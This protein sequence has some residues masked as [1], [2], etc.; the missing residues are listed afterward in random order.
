MARRWLWLAS[1]TLL[2]AVL[3]GL[4]AA[5][6]VGAALVA[7]QHHPIGPAPPDLA[8]APV[9]IA[10]PDGPV[11]GWYITGRPEMASVLLLH[12]IR[13]D[14]RA[15]LGRARLLSRQGYAVL[16]IDLPAHGESGGERITLGWREAQGVVAARDWLRRQRPG[17]ALGV[18]G[19]SLGGA[20]VLLGPMPAGYDAV[21]LEA[22]YDDAG[23]ALRNRIAIR[24]GDTAARLLWP[25]LAVQAGPRMGVPLSQL[26]PVSRMDG[27]GAPVLVIAGGKDRHTT[28]AQSRSLF[29]HAR[30]P[31]S[32]WM[33]PAAAHQD[34]LRAD[35]AGY[36]RHVLDF[37]A[38][39]LPPASAAT[40]TASKG[41]SS[42]APL[43]A[44]R[45]TGTRLP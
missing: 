33:L 32:L 13:A 26:R 19:V 14:R 10:G 21:V 29:A 4:A 17:H 5:W 37:L 43:A 39:Y 36:R 30:A 6:L 25:L 11:C 16:L 42:S 38:R 2:L 28:P 12:G 41:Q 7:P 27:L 22:V 40:A 44:S 1:A 35:P 9:T 31:K 20:S 18:I 15:M 3:G 8:V 45:N 23:N 34:F 24:M